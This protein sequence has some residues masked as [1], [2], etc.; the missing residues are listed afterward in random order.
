MNRLTRS[1]GSRV[2]ARTNASGLQF[3][4]IEA[5]NASPIS[6]FFLN[7]AR[8]LNQEQY[9]LPEVGASDAHFACAIGSAW[10]EFEG[11]TAEDLR[12]A[13]AAGALQGHAGH[14]PSL[15]RL[16]YARALSLP[17]VG[18]RA[19]PKKLGWRRT[20]LSFVTRYAR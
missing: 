9:K 1:I 14:Y 16:G 8:R 5:C 11:K 10:T 20:A 13:F 4:A 6:R 12:R 18:L 15:R 17:V 19:T 7:T 3:D 2:F